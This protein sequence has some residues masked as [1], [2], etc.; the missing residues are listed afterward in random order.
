VINEH[1]RTRTLSL[2]ARKLL[3]PVPGINIHWENHMR[4]ENKK[5][6]PANAEEEK[7][8]D[9]KALD[10]VVGGDGAT[11]K[12][13]EAACKGTHIPKVTIE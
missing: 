8:L 12:L 3:N 5:P 6:E 10:K 4:N 11:V 13:Y 1:D 9:E 2:T 7:Q